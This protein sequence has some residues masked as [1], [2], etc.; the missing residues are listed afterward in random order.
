VSGL[1]CCAGDAALPD[2]RKE[3]AD[4]ELRVVRNRDCDGPGVGSTLHY[5]MTTASPDF[6]E[7]VF[8]KN[9][10][11]VLAGKNTQFTHAPLRSV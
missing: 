10:A 6:S 2:D 5:H 8:F 7:T 9:L 3:C 4:G 1:E 11:G